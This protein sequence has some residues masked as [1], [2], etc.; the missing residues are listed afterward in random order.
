G[1][2]WIDR[3]VDLATMPLYV[4]AGAIIPLDPVRQY[5]SQEVTEPTTLRVH[6][7]ADGDFV[8]YDDDGQSLGYQNGSDDKTVWIHLHWNDATRAL[9]VE[10]DSRMKQWPAGTVRVFEVQPANAPA[11]SK[12]ARVEFRGERIQV[13]L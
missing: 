9:T 5:T 10:P 7:G 1:G 3:P 8:L 11:G 4:R 12:P 13:Q 2:R 6:P